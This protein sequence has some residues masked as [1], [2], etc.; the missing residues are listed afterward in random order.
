MRMENEST[1]HRNQEATQEEGHNSEKGMM[2]DKGSGCLSHDRAGPNPLP[3][4]R[5]R[6]RKT[7]SLKSAVNP[8]LIQLTPN[9]CPKLHHGAATATLA[10][11]HNALRAHRL[12]WSRGRLATFLFSPAR[13]GKGGA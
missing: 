6:Q 5:E 2:N 10:N 7:R 12:A 8:R 9:E 4:S 1:W 11:T 3:A 13:D